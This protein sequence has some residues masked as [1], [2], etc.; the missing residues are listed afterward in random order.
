MENE[1]DMEPEEPEGEIPGDELIVYKQFGSNQ[2]NFNLNTE[3][4]IFGVGIFDVNGKRV[5]FRPPEFAPSNTIDISGLSPSIYFLGFK[6]RDG[7]L[8]KAFIKE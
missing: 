8:S 6:L 4:P 3:E 7:F 5:W 1:E 2:L